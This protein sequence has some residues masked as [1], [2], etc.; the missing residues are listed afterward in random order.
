MQF[1]DE[2]TNRR[3]QA[4]DISTRPFPITA[5]R[6]TLN[7]KV[8]RRFMSTVYGGSSQDVFPAISPRKLEDHGLNDWMYPPL[9]YHPMAPRNP[10]EPGFYFSV[11]NGSRALEDGQVKRVFTR[12][13]K[14]PRAL[15]LYQGQYEVHLSESIT[16]EEWQ[17]QSLIVRNTWISQ[18]QSQ[19]WG[20]ALRARI[21]ARKLANPEPKPA[22]I[23]QILEEGL[24]KSVTKEEVA[25][26]LTRGDEVEVGPANPAIP[27]AL[28]IQ[29]EPNKLA[30][31]LKKRKVK[32]KLEDV[33]FDDD[34]SNKRYKAH[35]ISPYPVPLDVSRDLYEV[36]VPRLFM[37]SE[38]GGNS[39]EVFPNIGD[40][41]FAKHG[42]RGF[43]YLCLD[44]HPQAPRIPGSPGL[45]F[46]VG[47]D[48]ASEW[49]GGI[50]RAFTRIYTKPKALWQYQGQYQLRASESITKEEWARQ[51]PEVRNTWISYLHTESWGGWT[52]AAIYGRKV[53]GRKPTSDEIDDILERGWDRKVT[54]E[55]VALA[56]TRGE[57]RLTVY[58]MKCVGYDTNFQRHLIQNFRGWNPEDAK[59]KA[60]TGRKRPAKGTDGNPAK[61]K[62]RRV[63][64]KSK[65]SETESESEES[66]IILDD[67]NDDGDEQPVY[68]ARGTRSRPRRA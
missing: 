59:K 21:Y 57:Q 7:E 68:I 12:V 5:S 36:M 44:A 14:S 51:T 48:Q 19:N 30:V 64:E 29:D 31:P 43:F 39:M 58:T 47:Y 67:D 16:K 46:S 53:F 13:T 35:G 42:F 45:W 52:R 41:K 15:W 28:A 10:G 55:E 37:C 65:D 60:K 33:K 26:A 8:S 11:D 61:K 49:E 22:D 4:A 66:I 24:D 23:E 27:L 20:S 38:Y 2:L 40:K 1:D 50:V 25:L 54:K 34:L 6:A 32:V 63:A 62:R 56:L 17:R 9:D 18:I 3:Y